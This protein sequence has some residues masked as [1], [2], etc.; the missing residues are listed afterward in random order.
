MQCRGILIIAHKNVC[1]LPYSQF[2]RR[3]TTQSQ[4][5]NDN[6]FATNFYGSSVMD[7]H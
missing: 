6:F 5:Q 4:P 3:R 2:R 1:S 7:F